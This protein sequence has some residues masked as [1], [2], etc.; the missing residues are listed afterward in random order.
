MTKAYLTSAVNWVLH[1]AVEDARYWHK[2]LTD[3]EIDYCLEK[4]NRVT[5][6]RMLETEK[7]RRAKVSK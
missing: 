1:S 5:V 2:R 7:R 6:R 4:E 3:E